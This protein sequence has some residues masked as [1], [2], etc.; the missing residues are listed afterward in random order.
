MPDKRALFEAFRQ[1]L[2]GLI[3]QIETEG[4][5]ARA[6]TRVDG[7][8][9]PENR[10]ERAAVTTQG[11][12]T[13]AL[14]KRLAE[15][16]EHQGLLERVTPAPRSTVVT[17]ALFLAEDNEGVEDWFYVLPGG[18]GVQL[19]EVTVISPDSPIARGLWGL[20]EGDAETVVR[21]AAEVEMAVVEVR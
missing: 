2:L 10:G 4:A 13:H 8:H 3:A 7:E 9:R 16:R 14:G 11:Y 1:H 18:L 17:G 19:G 20:G 5:A 15:L 6:G 21:G 12:L